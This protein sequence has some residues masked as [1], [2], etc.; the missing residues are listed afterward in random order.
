[1]FFEQRC[2]ETKLVHFASQFIR[3]ALQHTFDSAEFTSTL[4]I[5]IV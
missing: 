3:V 4:S 1:M 5:S 2:N